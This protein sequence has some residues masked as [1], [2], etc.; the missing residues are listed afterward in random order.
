MGRN[1]K[2]VVAVSRIAISEACS[3][4]S[5]VGLVVIFSILIFGLKIVFLMSYMISMASLIRLKVSPFLQ[6]LDCLVLP[7]GLGQ[8]LGRKP[9][10]A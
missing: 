10:P 8:S 3:V 4:T 9:R 1:I 5:E 7:A 6:A 2:S